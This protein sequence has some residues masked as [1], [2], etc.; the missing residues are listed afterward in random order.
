MSTNKTNNYNL[1]AWVGTDPFRMDEFNENFSKLDAN[2]GTLATQLSSLAASVPRI[3]YGTYTGN[4][5]WSEGYGS[6]TISV[7]FQPKAVLVVRSG[8]IWGDDSAPFS[9][10]ALILRGQT[11]YVYNNY[12]GGAVTSNGFQ[13]GSYLSRNS[14]DG[15]IYDHNSPSLNT[16]GS[17]YFYLAIG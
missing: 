16:T 3:A 15:A 10:A 11:I 6:Q 1:H 17:T 9:K 4:K 14:Y 12:V 5:S 13:V 2:L 8:Y 7:G